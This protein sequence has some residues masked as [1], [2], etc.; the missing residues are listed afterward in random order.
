MIIEISTLQIHGRNDRTSVAYAT[1]DAQ[2]ILLASRIVIYDLS[3]LQL[4]GPPDEE[5]GSQLGRAAGD[6]RRG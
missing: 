1:H 2:W 6:G 4:G 5:D 3:F